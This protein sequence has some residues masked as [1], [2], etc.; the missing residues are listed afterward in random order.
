MKLKFAGCPQNS[1]HNFMGGRSVRLTLDGRQIVHVRLI[2][3]APVV[4]CALTHGRC[5]VLAQ[6]AALHLRWHNQ[7]IACMFDRAIVRRQGSKCREAET[8]VARLL[9]PIKLDGDGIDGRHIVE[10]EGVVVVHKVAA[11]VAA[12][13]VTLLELAHLLTLCVGDLDRE[14]D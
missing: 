11:Q 10:R 2:A 14:V 12:L 3:D 4:Q 7:F 8:A 9:S 6:I 1:R 5:G 13:E